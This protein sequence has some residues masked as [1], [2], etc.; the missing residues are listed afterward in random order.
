MALFGDLHRPRLGLRWLRLPRKK[1]PQDFIGDLM[2]Q[3]VG[4][5]AS[6]EAKPFPLD[7]FEAGI[8]YLEPEPPG[9]DV[10]IAYNSLS[11]RILILIYHAHRREH[12]LAQNILPTVRNLSVDQPTP[13]SIFELSCIVDAGMTLEA[14]H[15]NAGDLSLDFIARG[16][17]RPRKLSLRQIAI[18]ELA[19]QRMP[20]ENWLAQQQ[21][22]QRRHYRIAGPAKTVELDCHGRTLRGL[23][24][25][26]RR[27]RRFF[28]TR[29]PI[30]LI[31][32]ALHDAARD[33]LVFVQSTDDDLA[34]R[35]L[36]TVGWA[37]LI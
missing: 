10:W 20:L 30:E 35:V 31:T 13:W 21:R 33:R 18:A 36:A 2:R 1:K 26:S 37:A 12:L 3:E 32:Y 9:R 11:Q 6:L 4:A 14:H 8:L 16:Q 28:F 29:L 25:P 17:R 7:G 19:L 22:M 23:V 34:R 5:M 27:R 15:L 24:C